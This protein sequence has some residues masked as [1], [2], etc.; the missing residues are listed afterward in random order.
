M[1]SILAVVL[2]LGSL[3]SCHYTFNA[4]LV[5]GVS[6]GDWV[7]VRRT[8]NFQSN[9]PVCNRSTDFSMRI[10]S[11][12]DLVLQVTDVNSID[13][14]C[15]TSQTRATASTATVAA[16]SQ[17]GFKAGQ[18]ISHPGVA[19]I[20]MAKAPGSVAD[21]DGAGAVWFKVHQISAVTDG[22]RTISW[23]SAGLSQINFNI[24]RNLPDGEYLVRIEHIALHS[25]SGFGGA[26]FYISCAQVK[27]TGGGN[28]TPGPLVSIPGVY[29]GNEPGIKVNIYY[30]VPATY[31]QPGPAV[32][33]G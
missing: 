18:A 20:Y 32:W 27:V 4:L 30:P 23:P 31:V 16:G 13:F 33:T 5:N 7:N 19:N 11:V 1:K 12:Y 15:Y 28:G 25:A 24:P 8:N 14:R 17:I 9:G 2:S 6:T 10:S 21:W 26:Q 3:A 29:N 22:G